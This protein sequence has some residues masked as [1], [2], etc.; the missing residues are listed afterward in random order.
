MD[1][2]YSFRIE[3][4]FIRNLIMITGFSQAHIMDHL[5]SQIDKLLTCE[6][7]IVRGLS[8]NKGWLTQGPT[9]PKKKIWVLRDYFPK[10]EVMYKISA[11]YDPLKYVE[12]DEQSTNNIIFIAITQV[13]NKSKPHIRFFGPTLES[14]MEKLSEHHLIGVSDLE[15]PIYKPKRLVPKEMKTPNKTKK[16]R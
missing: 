6:P 10:T 12:G 5:V 9:P 11:V 13:I 14:L 2:K 1:L 7:N 16:P 8:M 3:E 15:L 4:V